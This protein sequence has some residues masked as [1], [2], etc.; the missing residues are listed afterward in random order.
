MMRIEIKVEG[1]MVKRQVK[2]DGTQGELYHLLQAMGATQDELLSKITGTP[3]R[4]SRI[5][6]DE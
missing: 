6:K 4:T 2:C 5:D 1:D 3:I